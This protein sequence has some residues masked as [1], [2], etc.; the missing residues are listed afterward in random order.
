MKRTANASVNYVGSP[1]PNQLRLKW[2]RLPADYP[3]HLTAPRRGALDTA[4]TRRR[5]IPRVSTGNKSAAASVGGSAGANCGSE[6]RPDT[7]VP[8]GENRP[9]GLAKGNAG[10]SRRILPGGILTGGLTWTG[11]VPCTIMSHDW[12][13]RNAMSGRGSEVS[14]L[15]NMKGNAGHSRRIL[16]GGILTGGLTWTGCPPCTIMSHD[17]QGRDH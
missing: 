5:N 9:G 13:G 12:Q 4:T 6:E 10:H 3:K 1:N 14:A 15:V 17:Q 2:L 16:P 8:L 7:G 11:H